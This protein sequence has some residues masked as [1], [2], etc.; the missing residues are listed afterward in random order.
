MPKVSVIVP[1]YNTEA[2]LARC[3]E[4]LLNQTLRDIEIVVVDDGSR[5]DCAALCDEFADRDSR[6]RVIHK[7]NGGLGFARNSGL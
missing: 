2:Y 6:I 7:Q 5:A 1:V 3:L 4:S